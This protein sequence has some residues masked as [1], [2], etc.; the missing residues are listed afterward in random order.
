MAAVAWPSTGMPN[1]MSMRIKPL[2]VVVGPTSPFTLSREVMHRG[3]Q[4]HVLMQWNHTLLADYLGLFGHFA[5]SRGGVAIFQIP[6]VFYRA[7]RGTKTGS[8]S[9]A[10]G[11][12]A[13]ATSWTLT[14]GSGT[15]SRGD[16]LQVPITSGVPM[17]YVVTS[18]EAAGVIKVSP[19][20]RTA[21]NIGT[22]ILH[23]ETASGNLIYDT[24]EL[25][26]PD[27]AESMPSPA[28]GY[29]QPFALE[30]VTALRASY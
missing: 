29:L 10:A 5:Q 24:M 2:D 3:H 8:V 21:M 7:K 23:Y 11:V 25:A 20:A 27:F 18:T 28:P 4:W 26:D 13:G 6:L 15:L 19:G 9:L 22:N 16:W 14:G 30:F 17:A 12:A 1:P